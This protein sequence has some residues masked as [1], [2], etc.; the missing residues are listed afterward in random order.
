MKLL[1]PTIIA[2]LS[3]NLT[4]C[5]TLNEY[6]KEQERKNKQEEKRKSDEN[7]RK[8]KEKHFPVDRFI[9]AASQIVD[10]QI[11]AF[12]NKA[13]RLQKEYGKEL[14]AVPKIKVP[15]YLNTVCSHSIHYDAWVGRGEITA[16]QCENPKYFQAKKSRDN[17]IKN[18]HN[19]YDS[20]FITL[21]QQYELSGTYSYVMC[22]Y[23]WYKNDYTVIDNLLKNPN[24]D[25]PSIYSYTS[26]LNSD[27][28]IM[29]EIKNLIKIKNTSQE[30]IDYV[31]RKCTKEYT[32]F[33]FERWVDDYRNGRPEREYPLQ[34]N[35]YR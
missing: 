33:N 4:Q 17:A 15:A 7:I 35:P 28:P 25:P 32:N 9:E 12:K 21:I 2:L 26:Y 19:K 22:Q 5:Y 1:K 14:Q 30:E 20:K 11:V 27:I 10:N 31:R 8:S 3:L 23:S 18:I 16:N 6:I 24:Y 13:I 29:S 34:L